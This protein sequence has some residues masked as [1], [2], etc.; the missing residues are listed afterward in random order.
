[1]KNVRTAL[2]AMGLTM[3]MTTSA[4]A[5]ELT[6]STEGVEATV[7]VEDKYSD[8]QECQVSVTR[9]STFLVTIPEKITLNGTKEKENSAAYEVTVK[10]DLGG[11]EQINVVPDSTFKMSQKGKADI[12]AINTLE[13]TAFSNKLDTAEA[14]LSD[15]GV[16]SSGKTVVSGMSAGE[17]SGTFDFEISVTEVT[18]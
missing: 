16:T 2:L 13:K 18:E 1:M 11:I 7:N 3:A 9:G 10:G 5:A 4:M 12:E 6:T 15:E 8:T 14:L 17:W